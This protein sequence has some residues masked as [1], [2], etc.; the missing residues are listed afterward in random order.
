MRVNPDQGSTGSRR[1]H[2][3][4][5]LSKI[6]SVSLFSRREPITRLYSHHGGAPALLNGSIF[7]TAKPQRST[8]FAAAARSYLRLWPSVWSRLP[9]SPGLFGTSTTSL[10]SGFRVALRRL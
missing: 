9:Y 5:V 1:R 2:S 4:T 3:H 6:F 10:P 8:R 7:S